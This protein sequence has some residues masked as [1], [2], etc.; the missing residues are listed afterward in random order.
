M[1]NKILGLIRKVF[2]RD[3]I[4][5]EDSP[6]YRSPKYSAI[7]GASA[8]YGPL[9]GQNTVYSGGDPSQ[10]LEEDLLSRYADYEDL[11]EV[12]ELCVKGS[13]LV[14]TLDGEIRI[15]EL[16]KKYRPNEIFKIIAYDLVS[17]KFV[18]ADAHSPRKTKVD[19][20]L[21]IVFD[22]G[23]V[24]QCTKNHKILSR[25]GEWVEAQT[26]NVGNSV[27]P[28]SVWLQ[29]GYVVSRNPEQRCKDTKD[30]F[31]IHKLIGETKYGKQE[32][33]YAFHHKDGNKVNNSWDNIEMV[34]LAEHMSI[35]K[36]GDN[37]NSRSNIEWTQKNK[38]IRSKNIKS[39][40]NKKTSSKW[41]NKE[42]DDV[43]G[44]YDYKWRRRK[45]NIVELEDMLVEVRASISL[46]EAAAKL[47]IDWTTL[48]RR[49][50]RCGYDYH[51]E[52][53]TK[54]CNHKVVSIKEMPETDVYDLTTDKYHNFVAN[55]IVVHN[56]TALDIISDDATQTDN[57]TGK[58]VHIDAEDHKI[59][60][61]LE[62][63]F[64]QNIKIDENMW[65]VCRTMCKYGQDYEEHVVTE[66]EGLVGTIFLPVPQMRRIDDDDGE[67]LG[68]IYDKTGMFSLTTE[69]FHKRITDRDYN[70]RMYYDHQR[71]QNVYE[72]W[73]VTHFRLRSKNRGS[74]YGW[75][76]LEAVRWTVKRLTMLED[77]AMIYK[78]QRA[79]QRYVF[80][81]DVGDLPPNEA[82]RYLNQVKSQIK[83]TKMV[84]PRCLVADTLIICN[85]TVMTIKDMANLFESR[86]T[87]MY[88]VS[89][90]L[91]SNK[92]AICRV[93]A[94]T[95]SGKDRDICKVTLDNDKVIRCTVDHPFLMKNGSYK[96][97]EELKPNEELM[98]VHAPRKVKSVQ[99]DGQAD[100]YDLTVEKYHNFA[101]DA[102]VFVHNTGKLDLAANM[103][104]SD[105]DFY[106]PVRKDKPTMA[107]ETVGGF[108]TS[109]YMDDLGYFKDKLFTGIKIPKDYLNFTEDSVS[110]ANLCLVPETKIPLLDGRVLTL[111]DL[112]EEHKIG[113]QNYVYSIDNR[114]VNMF[115]G[116]IIEAMWTRKD[117]EVIR[118]H[119]SNGSFIDCTPD[120]PFLKENNTYEQASRLQSGECLMPYKI[121][122]ADITVESI[123]VLKE[124]RDCCDLTI[125]NFHNFATAAG[126]IVH[127]S[128]LDVRWAR[129]V[130][131][132]QRELRTGLMNMGRVHLAAL[133]QDPDMVEF[134]VYLTAPSSIF[135][136]AAMEVKQSQ[137]EIA[138]KFRVFVDDYW[139][140][141]NIL[142]F[143][144]KD[145]EGIQNRLK[146]QKAN[147]NPFSENRFPTIE[148]KRD[149]HPEVRKI[150]NDMGEA[151]FLKDKQISKR[152]TELKGFADDLKHLLRPQK[153]Q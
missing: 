86:S 96:L 91:E 115:G 128:T 95:L 92:Q 21:E 109:F 5:G 33:G 61:M 75:S 78:L 73:E 139:I 66:S 112:I 37:E 130:I 27:M 103:T 116:K 17:K 30:K 98:S 29:N 42:V 76:F 107:V 16:A 83:K 59:K 4:G 138:E 11:E 43:R 63:C 34:T 144:D 106:I 149:M 105:E 81:V 79:S 117:A 14:Y 77:A 148:S 120:H 93:E 111:N 26:L 44:I 137:L 65:E 35:H 89:Y 90:N 55:S 46:A 41:L 131:R 84:D 127:N 71:N 142:K 19:V 97:A 53:G 39:G 15:D 56:S 23:H 122:L 69:E 94:A 88:V 7:Y 102:G 58:I 67:S 104:S 129:T 135:E 24:L 57:V 48:A 126:C 12:P 54:V 125:E 22:T 99:R 85:G 31:F 36:P 136:M 28:M 1:A 124:R 62:T 123:E 45:S 47:E 13:T 74:Q 8:G 153:K 147:E 64:H 146:Q 118:V 133:G 119:L 152:L 20:V 141:N 114:T 50:K 68:F 143:S 113:K 10:T 51:N 38:E 6:R 18:V 150:L 108:D 49:L 100:V 3:R 72:D 140:M 9:N 110:K 60:E 25:S 40:K 145:I 132:V 101:L 52:V 32:K 70:E 82:L 151:A 87:P 134:N 80:N 121:G 2:R